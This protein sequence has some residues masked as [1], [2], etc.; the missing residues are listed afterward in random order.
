MEP[1][2]SKPEASS[3]VQGQPSDG[4]KPKREKR[5]ERKRPKAEIEILKEKIQVG[6]LRGD[7]P[8]VIAK[9]LDLP[10]GTLYRYMNQLAHETHEHRLN[11]GAQLLHA[12]FT[13]TEDTIRELDR[14]YTETKDA[15]LLKDRADILHAAFDRLQKAG[16]IPTAKTEIEGNVHHNV[17]TAS[18]TEFIWGKK[19]AKQ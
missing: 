4:D 13:R 14:R 18:L 16:F 7:T 12:Y 6:I 5:G 19:E 10:I 11:K 3:S 1:D 8:N 15:R 2:P 17:S 9:A